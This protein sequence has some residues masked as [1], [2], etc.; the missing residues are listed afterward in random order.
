[1]A[2]GDFETNVNLPAFKS[3]LDNWIVEYVSE[4]SLLQD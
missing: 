3:S 1:M 4:V 2:E